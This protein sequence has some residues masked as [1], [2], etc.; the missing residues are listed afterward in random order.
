[1]KRIKKMYLNTIFILIIPFIF[2]CF[3]NFMIEKPLNVLTANAVD[4]E[5]EDESFY[6]YLLKLSNHNLNEDSFDNITTLTI[7][8]STV[9]NNEIKIISGLNQFNWNN[10]EKIVI[11][12]LFSLESIDLNYENFDNIFPNLKTIIIN[13]NYKLEYL[14]IGDC[15]NLENLEI[16]GNTYLNY[17]CLPDLINC[18]NIKFSKL[19]VKDYEL[20]LSGEFNA[21]ESIEI[22]D[23]KNIKSLNFTNP[24]NLERI[25][26]VNNNSLVNINIQNAPKLESIEATKL[27]NLENLIIANADKLKNFTFDEKDDDDYIEI[28]SENLK[29]FI[30]KNNLFLS[31]I[32]ILNSNTLNIVNL[33]NCS[34]IVELLL[35]ENLDSL[36]DLNLCNL[37]NATTNFYLSNCPN[38]EIL[39][40]Y[41]CKLLDETFFEQINELDNL[42]YLNLE[43]TCL[44]NI[45]LTNKVDLKNLY[46]GNYYALESVN[47]ENIPNLTELSIKNCEMLKKLY[48]NALPSLENIDL[49]NVKNLENIIING[50]NITELYIYDYDKLTNLDLS[51]NDNL[52]TLSVQLCPILKNIKVAESINLETIILVN[53]PILKTE[54]TKQFENFSKLKIFLIEN[55]NS[56]ENIKLQNCEE[57]NFLDLGSLNNLH[58]ISLTNIGI[59]STNFSLILPS[60]FK[61]LKTIELVNLPTANLNNP[62]IVCNNGSVYEIIIDNIPIKKIDFSNNQIF[63]V[64]LKNLTLIEEIDLSNN[65]ISQFDKLIDQFQ[66]MDNLIYA[67]INGNKIDFTDEDT[68][69]LYNQSTKREKIIIGIQN[70]T[71]KNNYS[72]NPTIFIGNFDNDI[73]LNIYYCSNIQIEPD[74]QNI[75]TNIYSLIKY[76]TLSNFTL[77]KG[78]YIFKFTKFNGSE[79]IN[80]NEGDASYYNYLPQYC[81]IATTKPWHSNLWFIL[82]IIASVILVYVILSYIYIIWKTKKK[83]RNQ[84]SKNGGSEEE[85]DDYDEED[86][87]NS[88]KYKNKV[89]NNFN[90]LKNKPQIN[91]KNIDNAPNS[92]D[93][94]INNISAQNSLQQNKLPKQIPT[95]KAKE[96]ILQNKPVEKAKEFIPTL[97]D[98]KKPSLPNKKS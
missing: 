15:T 7:D 12:N 41:N 98:N 58:S 10:L 44:D 90:M 88:P 61:N 26:L 35:P 6:E 70:V 69:K 65:N 25:S 4:I 87:D 18:K 16:C 52:K 55:C 48:M 51:N 53:C 42:M 47:L 76:D 80:I 31:K 38:L 95:I 43:K 74:I 83:N 49:Y 94:E 84:I 19:N 64:T 17:L 22:T 8:S 54:T 45:K 2:F 97:P 96:E 62:E 57:M 5:I 66:S 11:K 30:I 9:L 50:T 81:T 93:E 91:N 63:S 34:E 67:N 40:L 71:N 13:K 27:S 73:R 36:T 29:T 24:A 37:I 33:E 28:I 32:K 82:I 78:T 3:Y 20:N 1:M 89:I 72:Y 23:S 79:F 14:N 77:N 59:E 85:D 68:L 75:D 56:F 60:E 21:L 86:Y 92:N 39:N 46:L